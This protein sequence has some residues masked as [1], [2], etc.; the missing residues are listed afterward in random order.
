MYFMALNVFQGYLK[1]TSYH[2]NSTFTNSG[3]ILGIRS[4]AWN[5]CKQRAVSGNDSASKFQTQ[6]SEFSGNI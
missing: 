1:L 3:L 2:S 6:R 4:L 5:Q